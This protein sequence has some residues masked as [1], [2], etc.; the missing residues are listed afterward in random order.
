MKDED[1]L[2]QL[3][4]DPVLMRPGCVLLQAAGGCAHNNQFMSMT[5]DTKDWLVAPTAN[6]S[7]EIN[8]V[9]SSLMTQ[10]WRSP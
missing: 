7:L 2:I 5:F 9:R 3:V 1:E 4:F 8:F 10:L 6:K